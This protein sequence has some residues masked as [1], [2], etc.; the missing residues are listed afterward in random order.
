VASA[1]IRCSD[2]L[3]VWPNIRP[4]K[5][6]PTL[7]TAGRGFTGKPR[8]RRLLPPSTVVATRGGPGP[9]LARRRASRRW[10]SGITISPLRL[11]VQRV[12]LVR[13]LD[14]AIRKHE[15]GS[16]KSSPPRVSDHTCGSLLYST[17][18]SSDSGSYKSG[19]CR[20]ISRIPSQ[21]LEEHSR[22]VLQSAVCTSWCFF[23]FRE[24]TCTL[25]HR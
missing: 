14:S 1:G 11:Q 15:R 19:A 4:E 23:R 3:P 10:V 7:S 20:L 22:T 5:N 2:S 6:N 18:S 8:R 9:C 17:G 12:A 24:K 21:G 16:V 25:V 13:C